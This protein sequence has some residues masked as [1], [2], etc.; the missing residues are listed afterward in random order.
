MARRPNMTDIEV[1]ESIAKL[2][3]DPDVKLCDKL[4][5]LRYKRRLY[6]R[7]LYARKQNGEKLRKM[8]VTMDNIEQK[9]Y[10]GEIQ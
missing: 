5:R 10:S 7:Q 3:S 9:F 6:E 4:I 1:E 8:G 2:N